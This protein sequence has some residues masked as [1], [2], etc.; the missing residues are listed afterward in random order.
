M[1]AQGDGCLLD[2]AQTQ[3]S[4]TALMLSRILVITVNIDDGAVYVSIA[5][6]VIHFA[7]V[8]SKGMGGKEMKTTSAFCVKRDCHR[9]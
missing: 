6:G 7:R 4:A 9:A 5:G 1:F 8:Q 2:F 3:L